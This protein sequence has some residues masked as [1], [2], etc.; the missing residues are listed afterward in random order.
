M[1]PTIRLGPLVLPSAGLIYIVGIWV[2][3]STVERSAKKLGLD[4]GSTYSLAAWS[5][6]LGFIG[7][8]LVFVVL[9][10]SAYQN[11]LIGIVWPVTSG[12]NIWGGIIIALAAA[13]LYGRAKQLPIK[14]SLDALTP[15]LL[16]GFIVVSLADLMSGPGYGTE[17][18]FFLGINL[19]GIRRH[20]VQ[21]Y[22]ILVA[23]MALIVWWRLSI[24]RKFEGQLFFA[25]MAIF[26]AGRLLVDGFR[27]NSP[28]TTNGYHIIQIISLAVLLICVYFLGQGFSRGES[29]ATM[30]E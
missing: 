17:T 14:S 25:T 19:F 23:S 7:A 3:L 5:I 29:E 9:H 8:R 16:V 21:L 10:W 11:N 22:E 13:F 27:A 20:A 26:S 15:G 24:G 18:S 4:A 6:V 1:F 12:F 30:Q 28:L 2:A